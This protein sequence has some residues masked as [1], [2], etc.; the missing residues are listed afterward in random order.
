[1]KKMAKI[2]VSADGVE[3]FFARAL[4]HARRL[5]RGQELPP[6]ITISFEDP[7]DMIRVLSAERIRLLRRTKNKPTTVSELAASLK[8][9]TRAVSR[10]VDLLERFGLLET[11]YEANP[12]HGRRR[13]I[14]PRAAN[15][16]LVAMI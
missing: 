3:G 10:D 4:E 9:D 8:R 12:G 7:A 16:Q 14:I 1:M 11:L 5:D 15:Y 13:V 2:R 6:E